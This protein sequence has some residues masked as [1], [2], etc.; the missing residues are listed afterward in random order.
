M[1]N[2]L[3]FG[4]VLAF[5]LGTWAN[6]A[7]ALD[8]SDKEAI[9]ALSNQAADD[10]EQ[11]RY[12]AAKDKFSRAYRL[13][14]VPKLAVWAA[15]V[16]EKLG[17]LVTA[18]E[19]Y[20]RALSLQPND[21]WKADVQQ[22]AKRDAQD[23]LDKLQTR[24][25]KLTIVI[26]GANSNDVSVTVDNV[27]VPSDL[28][29]VERYADPGQRK[30]VG[31]RGDEVVSET[32]T[33]AEGETKQIVLK[34]RNPADS[35]TPVAGALPDAAP[36][37]PASQIAPQNNG[38]VPSKTTSERSSLASNTQP[39]HDQSASHSS[40]Q[41]TWGWLGVGVGAAGVAFGATTGLMVAIKYPDLNSKCQDR[42]NCDPKYSSEVSTYHTL[43]SLSPVGFIVGGVATAAGVTLLLTSPTEKSRAN[44]ELWLLP[45]AAGF[46]GDF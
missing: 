3:R 43:R 37:L 22:R 27:Q 20:L 21:L 13:A 39:A 35:A 29:G 41:R 11:G 4:L 46:A 14:E 18:Y 12:E 10:F 45:N 25:P 34:F 30:I 16:N 36:V 28:L 26:E 8:D 31:K 6:L 5:A 7:H 1:T 23:E 19:L 2:Q 9:R 33:L 15:R 38:P 24:I 32:A 17:H 44:V 40:S 42:N